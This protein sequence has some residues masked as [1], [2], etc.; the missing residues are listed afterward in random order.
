MVSSDISIADAPIEPTNEEKS[1]APGVKRQ[2]IRVRRAWRSGLLVVCLLMTACCLSRG[3]DQT[4][5]AWTARHAE[6]LGEAGERLGVPVRT[7]AM[8][9]FADR[10]AVLFAA[11]ATDLAAIPTSRYAAGVDLGVAYLD[12]LAPVAARDSS[13]VSIPRGFYKL[14]G[15]SEEA[16]QSATV[17]GHAQ[18]IDAA[19]TVVAD[20]P[21][22]GT[23]HSP[24]LRQEGNVVIA[25]QK[26]PGFNRFLLCLSSRNFGL[27]VFFTEPTARSAAANRIG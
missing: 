15:F 14:R 19:G 7:A 18:L 16:R 6:E 8:A 26:I 21:A 13:P 10:D 25:R 23:H 1:R 11:P 22:E 17:G 2:T 5:A 9:Q 4:N 12:I 27:C 20:L 3:I 24:E